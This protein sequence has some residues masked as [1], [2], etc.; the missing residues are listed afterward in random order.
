MVLVTAQSLVT[1]VS[2]RGKEEMSERGYQWFSPG[3]YCGFCHKK[4][5]NQDF[6]HTS[7]TFFHIDCYYPAVWEKIKK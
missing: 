6:V 5:V 7:Q 2:R 1:M 3:C 4:I